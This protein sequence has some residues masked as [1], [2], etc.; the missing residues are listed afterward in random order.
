M[1]HTTFDTSEFGLLA[2]HDI[3]E[4]VNSGGDL[5]F[6]NNFYKNYFLIL[7]REILGLMT[8]TFHKAGI[9]RNG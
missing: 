4:K 1:K 8:D 2:L 5:N 3:V 7:V 6:T 9:F